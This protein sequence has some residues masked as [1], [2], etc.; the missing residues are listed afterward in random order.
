MIEQCE[1]V[2]KEALVLSPSSNE[3]T[4]RGRSLVFELTPGR[5]TTDVFALA[6]G[7]IYNLIGIV[8]CRRPLLLIRGA[9]FIKGLLNGYLN[10][11]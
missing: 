8:I 9:T 5:V 3:R 2:S 10:T 6:H 1:H 7:C 4:A 11:E